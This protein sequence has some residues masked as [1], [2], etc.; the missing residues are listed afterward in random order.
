MTRLCREQRPVMHSRSQ[1]RPPRPDGR[2]S[3]YQ[4]QEGGRGMRSVRQQLQQTSQG[5][6]RA[7]RFRSGGIRRTQP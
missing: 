5:L 6:S 3:S 1:R 4:L 2:L 7:Q